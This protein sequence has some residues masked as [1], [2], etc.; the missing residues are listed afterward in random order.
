MHDIPGGTEYIH[1]QSMT[2]CFI[3]PPSQKGGE[4]GKDKCLR[5]QRYEYGVMLQFS[6]GRFL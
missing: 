4:M 3:R 5:C 2:I 1:G 6:S